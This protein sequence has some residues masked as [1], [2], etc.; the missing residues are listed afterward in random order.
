MIQ[1]YNEMASVLLMQR[2]QGIYERLPEFMKVKNSKS[3][4]LALT[5]NEL[6]STILGVPEGAKHVRGR[7]LN[8]LLQDEAAYNE[9]LSDCL[10]ASEPS[11]GNTGQLLVPS[12]ADICY[13]WD[14][15]NDQNDIAKDPGRY[16]NRS[17]IQ[18]PLR[19][20]TTWHNDGNDFDVVKIHYTADPFK[21]PERWGLE[22][23]EKNKKKL[24]QQKWEKEMEINPVSK[25]GELIYPEFNPEI[26]IV[27]PYNI[28]YKSD[29]TRYMGIDYGIA[30]PT[31]VLWIAVFEKPRRIV[32]Y[33]EHYQ[34]GK[35]INWHCDR[36]REK[37]GWFPREDSE[38]DY[39]WNHIQGRK[40]NNKVEKIRMRI[41]DPSVKKQG[42]GRYTV[43]SEYNGPRNAMGTI[44]GNNSWEVGRE[45]VS[46][47]FM[48]RNPD[49]SPVFQVFSSC[50]NFIK[51]I[52]E[53]REEP[54]SNL[55]EQRRDRPAGGKPMKKADHL[56]DVLRY[57][58]LCPT[59]LSYDPESTGAC[60]FEISENEDDDI[61]EYDINVDKYGRT[62]GYC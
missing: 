10:E 9:V 36:I 54:L 4:M 46:M 19:G 44:L 52:T 43:W 38:Y 31:G 40:W 26:H 32:V 58:V 37:E 12:S 23:W 5:L 1:S 29:C 57:L 16:R 28:N 33:R 47:L 13:F 34:A 30:S 3:S 42:V 17:N 55:Q 39:P 45:R 56:M 59:N 49:G 53:Y 27:E 6:D 20:I 50:V 41:I 15:V 8:L 62:T 7:T 11:I 60:E 18:Q 35:E 61:W 21:D 22:W 48:E 24:P 51:E 14:M 2:A 25:A